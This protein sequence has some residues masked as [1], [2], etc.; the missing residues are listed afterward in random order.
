[1]YDSGIDHFWIDIFLRNKCIN[2]RQLLK[3]FERKNDN[4]YNLY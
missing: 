4:T 3:Y 2:R 1:M